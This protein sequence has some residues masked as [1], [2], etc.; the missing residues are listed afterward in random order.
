M[1]Q[2]DIGLHNTVMTTRD[3]AIRPKTVLDDTELHNTTQDN[4]GFHNR[5]MTIRDFEIQPKTALDFTIRHKTSQYGNDD[6]RLYRTTQDF[7]IRHKTIVRHKV[8]KFRSIKKLKNVNHKIPKSFF[9]NGLI[10]NC[11]VRQ[12]N[13]R[14]FQLLFAFGLSSSA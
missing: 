13:Q 14:C 1:A 5:V 2:D 12:Q 10:S 6:T 8:V 4:I 7:T 11:S 9:T 3:F